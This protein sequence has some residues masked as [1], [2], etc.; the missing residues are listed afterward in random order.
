M[1]QFVPVLLGRP[2]WLVDTPLGILINGSFAVSIFFVLSGFVVSRAAAK[3]NDPFFINIPLRYLRLALPVT[4]SVIFAWGLL[5][6]FPNASYRLN[7]ILP[8]PWLNNTYQQHIPSFFQALRSGFFDALL[9]GGPSVYKWNN[10]LWTMYFEAMGSMAI[11]LIYGVTKGWLRVTIIVLVGVA[12]TISPYP[13]FGPYYF[14]F[15]LG[16]LMMERW[17][18]GKLR[19]F[20]PAIALAAGVLLGF[21]GENF[22]ERWKIPH[23]WHWLT[24]GAPDGL[25]AP[26]A[27]ALILYAA[28]NLAPLEKILSSRIPQFLG[29]ISFPLYLVHVPLLC[30]VFALAYVWIQPVSGF[31]LAVL[32]AVY[33]AVSLLLATAG[34]IWIDKPALDGIAW[35]RRELRTCYPSR[36]ALK[37]SEP[38]KQRIVSR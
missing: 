33:L 27:A 36:N 35:A 16:A 17:T 37:L 31:T 32:F 23:P 30:T 9:T 38:A 3:S 22:V 8:N 26:V 6:L 1:L 28:L 4:A 14:C 5:T 15:V 29:R 12:V 19:S 13:R 2:F 25:I 21:P 7:L 18:A 34:E 10:P 24:L 20:S 11:Y